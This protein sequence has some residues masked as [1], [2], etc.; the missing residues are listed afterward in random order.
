MFH[1]YSWQSFL[2]G[3][4]FQ[5]WHFPN[6]WQQ[7]P[8]K[9]YL[10]SLH[11]IFKQFNPQESSWYPWWSLVSLVYLVYFQTVE[12]SSAC[13]VSRT[14]D[15]WSLQS[16]MLHVWYIFTY[17][18]LGDFYLSWANVGIHI[19]ALPAPCFASGKQQ[20]P[21]KSSDDPNES[22]QKWWVKTRRYPSVKPK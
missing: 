5:V 11:K 9:S 13:L 15:R 3:A 6:V 7:S 21:K 16:H 14:D 1:S 10:K 12:V 4:T 8:E 22:G 18:C 19:P 17:I 20:T 2:L